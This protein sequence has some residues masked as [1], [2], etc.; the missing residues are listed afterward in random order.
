MSTLIKNQVQVPAKELSKI[1]KAYNTI[2]EFLETFLDRRVLYKEEF[3]Q[4]LDQAVKEV[5]QHKTK[6][7]KNFADFVS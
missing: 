2:G 3:L 4:G 7:V 1:L 5:G 6:K